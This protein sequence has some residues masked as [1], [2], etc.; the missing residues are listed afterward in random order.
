MGKTMTLCAYIKRAEDTDGSDGYV[1]GLRSADG[2]EV[3]LRLLLPADAVECAVLKGARL[4]VMLSPCGRLVLDAEGL[5]EE[6]LEV[7]SADAPLRDLTLERLVSLCLE[8][9]LLKGEDNL[10]KD[11]DALHDQLQRALQLVDQTRSGLSRP[12]QS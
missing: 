6:A 5:S 1:A 4:S 12:P 2:G 10:S 9:A 11:L 3:W 8:P 7:A